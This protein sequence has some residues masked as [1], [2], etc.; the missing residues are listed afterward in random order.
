MFIFFV[1]LLFVLF[2]GAVMFT[3]LVDNGFRNA[4]TTFR[5]LCAAAT[6]VLDRP[7]RTVEGRSPGP[8][9]RSTGPDRTPGRKIAR[10]T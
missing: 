9:Q 4:G 2:S 8:V 5:E 3:D 7:L 10:R 6:P 1:V